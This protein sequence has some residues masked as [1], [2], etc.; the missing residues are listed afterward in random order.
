M[1]L[2]LELFSLYEQSCHLHNTLA[3]QIFLIRK[4][5]NIMFFLTQIL[6]PFLKL[7][8]LFFGI[9]AQ[10]HFLL[11]PVLALSISL[12]Q[13]I[14]CFLESYFLQWYP[15]QVTKTLF[16]IFFSWFNKI[17][18]QRYDEDCVHNYFTASISVKNSY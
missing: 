8:I 6:L 1:F 18:L 11:L 17:F 14:Q 15:P 7:H 2:S 12:L 16:S 13:N 9:K 3:M 4:R 5:V 10:L